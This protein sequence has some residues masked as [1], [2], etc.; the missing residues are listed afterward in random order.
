MLSGWSETLN[1]CFD[2]S[3]TMV[4]VLISNSNHV[5]RHTAPKS[6]RSAPPCSV[7]TIFWLWSC[8]WP[9]Y[10]VDRSNLALL[11]RIG[12]ISAVRRAW[13]H[14]KIPTRTEVT[15]QDVSACQNGLIWPG[16]ALT[17]PADKLETWNF[18][19]GPFIIQEICMPNLGSLG[20][21]ITKLERGA[22]HPLPCTT[23]CQKPRES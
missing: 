13:L 12:I 9:L 19:S 1:S 2:K 16:P 20:T 22:L 15:G 17:G 18:I 5:W 6:K 4:L 14:V 23:G 21:L 8:F 10:S 3:K 11:I 7:Y